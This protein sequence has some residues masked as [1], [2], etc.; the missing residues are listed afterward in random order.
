MFLIE[1]PDNLKPFLLQPHHGHGRKDVLFRKTFRRQH[2][3]G[4]SLNALAER[5]RRRQ[6]QRT[7][8]N[9]TRKHHQLLFYAA[10][11]GLR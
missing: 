10:A 1:E 11:C 7:V 5:Q 4:G 6:G 2:Q 9:P 3:R 8:L